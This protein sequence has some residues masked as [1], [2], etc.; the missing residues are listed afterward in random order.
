MFLQ[1]LLYIHKNGNG[2]NISSLQLNLY[3]KQIIQMEK[4]FVNIKILYYI[5]DFGFALQSS[6]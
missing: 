2:Y 1:H 4:I 5:K 6:P 3:S